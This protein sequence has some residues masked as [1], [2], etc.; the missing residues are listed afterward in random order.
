[1]QNDATDTQVVTSALDT[2]VPT[3]SEAISH[4]NVITF[5][6]GCLFL[7][8]SILENVILNSILENVINNKMGA[9]HD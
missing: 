1:M 3:R 9:F 7:L 2:N 6:D 5:P 4:E 8:N